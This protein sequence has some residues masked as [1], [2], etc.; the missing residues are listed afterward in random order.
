MANKI[1]GMN[2]K[3]SAEAVQAANVA[4]LATHTTAEATAKGAAKTTLESQVKQETAWVKSGKASL[5]D[6]DNNNVWHANALKAATSITSTKALLG[7][8]TKACTA[9]AGSQACTWKTQDQAQLTKLEAAKKT[10]DAANAKATATVKANQK[11]N[12]GTKTTKAEARA[13]LATLRSN[14]TEATHT[15]AETAAEIKAK[16][17]KTT[18]A[19]TEDCVKLTRKYNAEDLSAKAATAA[20]KAQTTYLTTNT[21]PSSSD[22]TI[23]III[24]VVSAVVCISG[25]LIWNW[26]GKKAAAKKVAEEEA[27]EK[28]AAKGGDVEAAL[29]MEAAMFVNDDCYKAMVDAEY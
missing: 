24:L 17:C 6:A 1:A 25:G 2:S 28:A 15:L 18:N 27:A 19:A 14:A 16:D 23:A 9:K 4:T 7:D 12:E 22:A 29:E 13:E 26:H 3:K 8:D 21:F 10:R 11:K 5:A 20:V